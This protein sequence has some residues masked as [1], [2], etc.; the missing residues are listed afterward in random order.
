MFSK[1][2]F[3][4]EYKTILMNLIFKYLTKLIF[5]IS[6]II[7]SAL[8]VLSQNDT[9]Q[10]TT[11]KKITLAGVP[12][13][14]YNRSLGTIFGGMGSMYYKIN[15]RDTI[16]PSSFTMLFGMYSTSKTY[17]AAG[18]QQLYLSKDN[19]RVNYILGT[20]DIYFQFF[21]GFGQIKDD[22]GIWVDFNT[23]MNFM[24]LDLKRKTIND[25]YVGL[26]ATYVSSTTKFDAQNPITGEDLSTTADMNSLGYN[27]LFDNRD[28]V[29]FPTKGFFIQFKNGFIR[30]AFGASE[31]FN[32]YEIAFNNFWDIKK[33]SKSIFVS[34]LF[35]DITSGDVP[36]SGENIIGSDDLRGYSE[37]RYRGNQVYAIQAELR[38]NIYKKFGMIGFVG[39]G[40]AVD[41][42]SEI[43]DSEILP[44]IG[45]GI[46]YLMIPKEN[47]NIGFDVG[48]G[49]DDWS[50]AFRIGE[51]FGR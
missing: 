47:I 33:N 44:S 27:L 11:T 36:F 34:R 16:S 1:D 7:L 14:N 9:V 15:K 5:V 13:I 18:I 21:Q 40:S 38:Q 29:N 8:S 17:M 28:N 32:S 37:G 50:L 49:R 39:F 20:G 2:N 3:L 45:F 43:L 41:E 10:T 42:V 6:L 23:K 48:F 12:I 25:L 30:E 26:E 24:I 51:T 22:A 46:R 31:N 19:W 35:A 4:I